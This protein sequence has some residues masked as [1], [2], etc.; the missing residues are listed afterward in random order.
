M[1]SLINCYLRMPLPDKYEIFLRKFMDGANFSYS[2]VTS[3]ESKILDKL[4]E[5]DALRQKSL[6][7]GKTL[8]VCRSACEAVWKDRIGE[9]KKK[10]IKVRM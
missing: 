3:I 4:N 5:R 1:E 9:R 10:R 6:L 7:E 8:E 2:L